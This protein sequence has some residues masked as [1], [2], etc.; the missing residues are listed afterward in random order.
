MIL[1]VFTAHLEMI[2]EAT[3]G[4]IRS[5]LTSSARHE[6]SSM[7]VPCKSEAQMQWTKASFLIPKQSLT[8]SPTSS[9]LSCLTTKMTATLN[10]GTAR[11]RTA[12]SPLTATCSRM[13]C[14]SCKTADPQGQTFI[15]QDDAALV[16][17]YE[18]DHVAVTRSDQTAADCEFDV[19]LL[20]N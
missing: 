19:V 3:Q 15:K 7:G 10:R 8:I 12:S 5:S 20:C 14:R 13:S 9:I 11:I 17:I 6:K 2:R 16:K 18:D 1:R 4:R